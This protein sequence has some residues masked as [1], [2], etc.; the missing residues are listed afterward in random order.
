MSRYLGDAW[1]LPY[2]D[3]Q[4]RPFFSSGV[5]RIQVCRSCDAPQHPPD[6]VCHACQGTEFSHRDSAGLGTV[7][8]FIIVHHPVH[9]AL[10]ERVPYAVALITLD[11]MPQIRVCGNIVDAAPE[12]VSI[13]QPV[14]A[15]FEEIHDAETG[16]D[17]T[18]PQWETLTG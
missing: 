6:D 10:T 18:I 17:L 13:G 15:T 5:I 1:A 7:H 4:I 9:P 2:L 8:S 3:P 16:E 12:A 11:D 14:R